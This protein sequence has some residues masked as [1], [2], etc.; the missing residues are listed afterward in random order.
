MSR[1]GYSEDCENL[2]LWRGAVDRALHGK[3]GQA[4]LR[5]LAA[6][7]DAMPEKRLV[8][9]AFEQGGSFCALGVVGHSRGIALPT[10]EADLDDLDFDSLSKAFGIAPAMVQEIMYMN[11]EYHDWT[12]PRDETPEQRW[13]R[14]RTW[15]VLHITAERTP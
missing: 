3:R 11:D 4:F 14:M 6:L 8:P 9:Y 10:S 1:S 15:I 7:L 13:Q 2:A 5:E 12:V